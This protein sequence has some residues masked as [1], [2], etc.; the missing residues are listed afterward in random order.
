MAI[1]PSPARFAA[2]DAIATPSRWVALGADERAAWGRCRGS[3]REPYETVVDHAHLAWRCTCPSRS[4]PCKHALA[5]LVMWVQG[6][7]PAGRGRRRAP[8]PGSTATPAARPPTPRRRQP[9]VATSAD[10]EPAS[11][12][13]RGA[14]LRPP[15]RRAHRPAAGGPGRARPLARRSPPHRPVRSGAGPLRDVGR[16]R[17][18]PRRRPS[19]CARQPGAAA[20]RRGRRPAGLARGRARRARGPPPPRRGRSPRPRPAERAGRR[21]RHVLRLAGPPGRRPGR[22]ARH[23][24][25]GRRRTQRHPRG[26]HRGPP[27]VAARRDVGGVGDDPVLRRLPPGAR[28]VARA[29]ATRSPPIST[30]TPAGRGGR[31]SALATRT[32]SSTR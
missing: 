20:G 9:T 14:G 13:G 1:A 27:H 29:S 8:R 30:A 11:A 32:T 19:R 10:D 18:P 4:H 5:L 17:R 22:R 23:R 7:G 21:R 28:H 24:H 3:G 6:P 16:P 12:G 25:V 26:S 15:A 2:A 31:C